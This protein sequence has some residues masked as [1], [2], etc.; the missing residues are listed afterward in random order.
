MI[1]AMMELLNTYYLSGNITQLEMI[2]RTIRSVIPD[3]V[4]AIQ[5]LGLAYLNRGRVSDA[6]SLFR[7]A[8]RKNYAVPEIK[9]ATDRAG[10]PQTELATSALYREAT[11]KHSGFGKLWYDLGAALIKLK[12]TKQSIWA[13]RTALIARPEFPDALMALGF[14]GLQAGDDVAAQEGFTKLLAIQPDNAMALRG[15]NNMNMNRQNL[16]CPALP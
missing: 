15:L 10:E 2:T 5:I 3:D 12:R 4:I 7:E 1:S 16:S 13:F 8:D 14:A 9:S 6:L 11:R